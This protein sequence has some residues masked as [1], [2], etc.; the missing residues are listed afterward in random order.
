MEELV[1][2]CGGDSDAGGFLKETGYI[3]WSPPNDRATDKFGFKALPNGQSYDTG[4]S[5]NGLNSSFIMSS[6]TISENNK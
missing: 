4:F 5:Y 3:H 6:T 2:Y 1:T